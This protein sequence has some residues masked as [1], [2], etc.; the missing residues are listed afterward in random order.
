MKK[1]IFSLLLVMS[2]LPVFG[3]TSSSYLSYD[4]T[5]FELKGRVKAVAIVHDGQTVEEHYFSRNGVLDEEN[6]SYPL[7]YDRDSKGRITGTAHSIYVWN[8]SRVVR[9]EWGTQGYEETRTFVYDKQ[10]K[11]PGYTDE[12]GTYRKYNY[13]EYDAKGNWLSRTYYNGAST[14][15][16]QRKIIYY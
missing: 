10:G 6:D 14:V 12:T 2:M 11:R 1:L 3:Q 7:P 13:S 15:K 9:L 8:G 5:L 16:E 4:W